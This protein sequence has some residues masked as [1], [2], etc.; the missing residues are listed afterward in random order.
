M[1]ALTRGLVSVLALGFAYWLGFGATAILRSEISAGPTV[2]GVVVSLLLLANMSLFLLRT[3][4][5]L[6]TRRA[7]DLGYSAVLLIAFWFIGYALGLDCHVTARYGALLVFFAAWALIAALRAHGAYK[8][9]AGQFAAT[10]WRDYLAYNAPVASHQ[11][12]EHEG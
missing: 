11:K 8:T 10:V 9:F 7:I 2:L 1:Y 6:L 12:P 3:H 5:G 4:P